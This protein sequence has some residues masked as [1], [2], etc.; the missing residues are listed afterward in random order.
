MIFPK[1]EYIP[2]AF[3]G[4]RFITRASLAGNY[5]R[6]TREFIMQPCGFVPW[7]CRHV[8]LYL[9]SN[10]IN[11]WARWPITELIKYGYCY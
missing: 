3:S 2:L 9:G 8:P 5:P 11:C 7:E 4:H 10:I 1:R 6:I